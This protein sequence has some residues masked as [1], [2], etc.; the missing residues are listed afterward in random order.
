MPL[1]LI[2]LQILLSIMGNLLQTSKADCNK[3]LTECKRGDDG[4][5]KSRETIVHRPDNLRQGF[6]G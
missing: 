2:K 3:L 6:I 5:I 4:K 1:S